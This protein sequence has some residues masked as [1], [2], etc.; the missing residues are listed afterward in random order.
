MFRAAVYYLFI[1]VGIS[2]RA[3]GIAIDSFDHG[4]NATKVWR[5]VDKTPPV[6]A[7]GARSVQFPCP[8]ERGDDRFYWDRDIELD[9]SRYTSLRIELS[10]DN[11][12][13]LRAFG[14][15]L[16]SGSGWYVWA[17]PLR[18]AGRQ[19]LILHKADFDTE[20]SPS[21]W[22]RIN[23]I[24]ISPWKGTAAHVTLTLFSITANRDTRV[25]IKPTLSAPN[26]AEK[27]YGGRVA[28]RVSGLL[29]E[30]GI[31]HTVV[32]EEEAPTALVGATLAILPC[33][34]QP[35]AS[36]IAA[37]KKMFAGGGKAMVFFGGSE[38]LAEAMGVRL[39]E[40][41][42]VDDL[43]RWNSYAFTEPQRWRVPAEIFQRSMSTR[44]A[45]P[46]NE[47]G[48]I[49]ATW[50][51]AS[52]QSRN[53][54]AWISTDRGLWMTHLLLDDDL[55]NKKRMLTGLAGSLDATVWAEAARDALTT[56]GKVDSY[57][58]FNRAAA[59]L[60]AA[61]GETIRAQVS[62]ARGQHQRMFAS[63]NAGDFRGALDAAG[64]VDSLMVDAYAL[65]Q[66]PRAGE[67]R[68]VWEHDGTGWYPGNWDATCEILA[69]SGINTVYAN[70]LWGGNAHF[71][72][73]IIPTSKTMKQYGD[74]ASL[75]TK[76]AKKYG[77]QSHLWVVCWNLG[78][79]PPEFLKK[80]QAEGRTQVSADGKPTAW[81]NPAHPKNQQMILAAISEAV[82]AHPFDGVHLDYIR[83]PGS[84]YDYS[85]TTRQMFEAGG[86]KV[87]DWPKDVRPG[88]KSR[89]AFVTWRAAQI[90][91]FVRRAHSTIKGINPNLKISAAVWGGW[92]DTI[93]SIG[94]DWATWIK[95][96][97]VDYVT[98]MNY[99]ASEYQFQAW[100]AKQLALPGATGKI[101]PGIGVTA[102][103]SQLRPDQVIEQI[104][105]LR[106][107]GAPGFVLFDLS[108]T[109]KRETLPA[110]SRGATRTETKSPPR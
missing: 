52:G 100:T 28:E 65:A 20:G 109:L 90:T 59:A 16:R 12:A 32:T 40:F 4:D 75:F 53:E 50:R 83:Y 57:A 95:E 14:I 3:A 77:L 101:M 68:G 80:M 108:H 70:L 87:S 47:R 89:S 34:Q 55:A 79:T 9:L 107:L 22:N 94:Q 5:A 41:Q 78:N 13:A 85:T 27:A 81:L 82:R 24:R 74:Q 99:T 102:D 93:A 61:G 21:G 58:D 110:L 69:R 37:L 42:S 56:A 46:A 39:G 92:P 31:S 17:K 30:A 35:P 51:N 76:A 103:E 33:N 36:V 48:R 6:I 84:E 97:T 18:E 60:D 62:A 25:V 88:G 45:M 11:P 8:F 72:N 23:R 104:A 67:V 44:L 19:T 26:A 43:T 15:Y 73:T 64:S 29:T 71:A 98:P 38:S 63:Y 66:K 91:A 105:T 106:R 2:A 10:C 86:G 7:P 49:I 54:P 96:G 1:L